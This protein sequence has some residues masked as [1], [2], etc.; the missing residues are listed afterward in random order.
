MNRF[1]NFLTGSPNDYGEDDYPVNNNTQQSSS[2]N[3]NY[4]YHNNNNNNHSS[5]KQSGYN[6]NNGNN[7]N[8]ELYLS[9]DDDWG[10]STFPTNTLRDN[11]YGS[12]RSEPRRSSS[13]AFWDHHDN[14]RIIHYNFHFKS[15]SFPA[16]VLLTTAARARA[17]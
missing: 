4:G 11:N 12:G 3:S 7:N 1:R 6:N 2:R 13:S 9:D 10:M 8:D 5:S 14:H 16:Y 15:S 17:P